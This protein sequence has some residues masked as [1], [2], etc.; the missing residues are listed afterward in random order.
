MGLPLPKPFLTLNGKPIAMHSYDLFAAFECEIVVVAN[1]EYRKFFP[2]NAIFANPGHRRQ[3][4]VKNGLAKTT[5][6]L[7]CIHDAARPYLHRDDLLRLIET[8]EKTGACTLASPVT[9]TI[10]QAKSDG[11]VICTLPRESLFDI[12][13]PQIIP[14]DQL[15]AGFAALGEKTVT[16]DVSII[17]EMG[18]T[19][20]IVLGSP[21]N[22]K[23]TYPS[24]L[25][26]AKV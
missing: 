7:I 4:S 15:E 12:Q 1:E 6:S 8:A 5:G 9:S 26:H 21:S 13:T 20:T 18:G 2:S 22:I 17:E 24:D 16:D 19:V 14:R 11:T 10:K 3:D 25:P 23:I